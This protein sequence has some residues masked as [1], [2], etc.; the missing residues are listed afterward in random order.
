MHEPSTLIYSAMGLSNE[1][2]KV[3]KFEFKTLGV[4]HSSPHLE[5][6]RISLGLEK[7]N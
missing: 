4:M 7:P 5:Y 2:Q 1:R 6:P 3:G